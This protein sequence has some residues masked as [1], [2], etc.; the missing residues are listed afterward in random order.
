MSPVGRVASLHGW[1]SSV[2]S[3]WR[4]QGLKGRGQG[5]GFDSS[6]GANHVWA[7]CLPGGPGL[8]EQHPGVSLHGKIHEGRKL[9]FLLSDGTTPSPPHA[10]GTQETSVK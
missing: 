3:G 1:L 10:V 9:P 7:L 5:A 2:T 4:G 8:G 6:H